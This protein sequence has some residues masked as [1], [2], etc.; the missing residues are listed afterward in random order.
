MSDDLWRIV[1]ECTDASQ[2]AAPTVEA[3][4]NQV[5]ASHLCTGTQCFDSLDAL[6]PMQ[7]THT[8]DPSHL[9]YLALL[10]VSIVAVL[11]AP[12][13]L[14]DAKVVAPRASLPPPPPPVS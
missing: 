7:P 1:C 13:R 11:F 4:M 8:V 14:L 9:C 3:I 2:G 6:V 10:F 12:R 5:T